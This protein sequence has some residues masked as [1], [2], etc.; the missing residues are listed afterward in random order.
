MIIIC[1]RMRVP[2]YYESSKVSPGSG[3]VFLLYFPL[4]AGRLHGLRCTV[5]T[6]AMAY[7]R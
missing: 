2:Q 3:K 7:V 5:D 6:C 1:A 4:L